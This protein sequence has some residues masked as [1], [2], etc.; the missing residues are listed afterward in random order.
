MKT[1]NAAANAMR[2]SGW[3]L[4]N[5][6]TQHRSN[7]T[8]FEIPILE[9]RR[10]LEPNDQAKVMFVGPSG[11]SERIWL[12]VVGVKEG[13]IYEGFVTSHAVAR[14]LP[15]YGKDVTFRPEHIIDISRT[16]PA[17]MR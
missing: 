4:V 14:D 12:A 9:E 1:K 3:H 17:T 7:P 8:T 16:G 10:K 2:P 13:P 15:E 11:S 5:A 6:E